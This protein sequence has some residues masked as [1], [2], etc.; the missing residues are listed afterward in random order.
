M[1]DLNIL[2]NKKFVGCTIS[3]EGVTAIFH[4]GTIYDGCL[5]VGADGTNSHV[6]RFVTKKPEAIPLP[7]RL[8]GTKV[9]LSSEQA[10][11]LQA[12]D[13]L[14]FAGGLPSVS[15]ESFFICMI[16]KPFWKTGT[17]AFIAL[18]EKRYQ[19]GHENS[20]YIY[21]LCLS[22][23][24][25]LDA[26]KNEENDPAALLAKFQSLAEPLHPIL[27]QPFTLVGP[28]SKIIPVTL[29][30]W[31][32]VSWDGQ[33]RITLMGEA[34]HAMTMFR[35][36]GGNHGLKDVIELI[37]ALDSRLDR[38]EPNGMLNQ[39][40]LKDVLR[41]YEKDMY[42]RAREAVLKSRQACLDA[43]SW[44]ALGSKDSPFVNQRSI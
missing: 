41:I 32:A 8:Y 20:T 24:I 13:P 15:E 3:E 33:G 36:E 19:A 31:D 22:S 4:D 1:R 7:V 39:E 34:A 43:H 12:I 21:Q 35:G 23:P 42:S 17:Y 10:A 2:W 44:G 11:P 30:D 25:A 5:L 16:N 27:K 28:N 6:R 14:Y 18:F 29:A 40:V 37:Q 26:A 9:V 38:D